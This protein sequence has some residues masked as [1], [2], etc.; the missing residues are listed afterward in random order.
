[1]REIEIWTDGG[2]SPNPGTGGAAAVIIDS[3]TKKKHEISK[4]Y[5][6]TTNNRMEITAVL[7]ALEALKV[8]C[9]ITLYSD[10]QYVCNTINNW[11]DNWIKK[12]KLHKKLNP[13]L[14]QKYRSLVNGHQIYA[15]WIKGH[16]GI[17]LNER[18]D[19]LVSK[20]IATACEP[21]PKPPDL[22]LELSI[23]P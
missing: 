5:T 6:D 7:L 22:V 13:D 9:N 14:W 11:L 10:S 18:C 19:Y 15:Q 23:K 16:S 20:A 17:A 12:N 1:M 3:L 21:E 2:C 8:P 4:G